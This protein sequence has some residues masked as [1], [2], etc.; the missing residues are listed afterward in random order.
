MANAPVAA[1]G[2]AEMASDRSHCCA[3]LSPPR[4]LLHLL[5]HRLPA[6]HQGMSEAY[7]QE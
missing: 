4:G 3:V 2:N 6:A 1:A 5:D 7:W